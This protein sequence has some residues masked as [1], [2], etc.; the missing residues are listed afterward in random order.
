M[1]GGLEGFRANQDQQRQAHGQVPQ[2]KC[3]SDLALGIISAV[4]M[5]PMRLNNTQPNAGFS[6]LRVRLVGVVF[7]A[8][9]PALIVLYFTQSPWVGLVI[10]GLALGAAWFGGERF[11]LRQVRELVAAVRRVS[12]GDFSTRT[13][14]A[15]E[16]GEIG[17]LAHSFDDMAANLEQR[18]KERDL[19]E[20][21]SL[22]RALQQTAVAALG[23]FALTSDDLSALWNQTVTLI[24]QML[25]VE[26]CRVLEL[27]PDGK[28][29]LMRA[30][31]GWK[32]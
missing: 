31:V 4:A 15:E 5:L 32:K 28:S 25:E 11:V 23:Q 26:F 2:G 22:N 20:Q 14:L 16:P 27:M 12:E 1:N 17:E 9:A 7:L 24:A 6:S 30:G 19:T 3:L 13:G 8:I 18:V 21:R 29:M 10:G